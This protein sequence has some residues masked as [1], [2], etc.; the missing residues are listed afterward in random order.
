MPSHP[1]HPPEWIDSAPVV[2][3]RSR[4]M[5]ATPDEVWRYIAD[6]E[7]WPEW[8]E[9]LTKVE[10]TGEASGVG[11]QRRATA[12]PISFDEV[13]TAWDEN[14]R[15]AFAVVGSKLPFL[16]GMAEEVR[17]EPIEGGS[18]VIYR[19]GLEARTGFGWMLGPM[20]KRMGRAVADALEE[21]DDEL[22]D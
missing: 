16:A 21:L 14:E 17:I 3:E 19:Q 12:G 20:A 15:F 5:A 10:V 1:E 22:D 13:F 11:G 18:R 9:S 2:V 6:H 8:F 7:G 4:K